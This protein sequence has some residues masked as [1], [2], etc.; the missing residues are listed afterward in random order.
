ME[1][2]VDETAQQPTFLSDPVVDETAQQPTFLTDPVVDKT[3]Q[4]PT[5]LTDPVV[6]ETAQQPT[7]L[8]DPVVDKTAQQ[9]TL[10]TEPV[11][12]ETARPPTFL[13]ELNTD[14]NFSYASNQSSADANDANSQEGSSTPATPL[15]RKRPYRKQKGE[16]DFL[17]V[18]SSL[19]PASAV[20]GGEA[21][22]DDKFTAE[23][24]FEYQW[25]QEKGSEHWMLQEHVQE[26]LDIGN[27][28]RKHP[29]VMKRWGK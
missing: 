21:G 20:E 14:S 1:P 12:D 9:P 24:L 15:A 10:L 13:T 5:F 19:A 7:F 8:T 27:F 28:K 3:A 4:Q 2:V 23:K 17:G 29:D 22:P 16:L 6:D 26:F 11:V 25:P 18:T